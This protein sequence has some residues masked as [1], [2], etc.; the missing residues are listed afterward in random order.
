M[1]MSLQPI[2]TLIMTRDSLIFMYVA[3]HEHVDIATRCIRE[4]A[5]GSWL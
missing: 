2:A 3:M 5:N 1:A 4:Q